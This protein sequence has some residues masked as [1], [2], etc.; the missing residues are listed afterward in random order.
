MLSIT[1][2][3]PDVIVKSEQSAPGRVATLVFLSFILITF[4]EIPS[5]SD[6]QLVN[7]D[8]DSAEISSIEWRSWPIELISFIIDTFVN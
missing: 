5:T 6:L 7:N 4:G 8:L 1:S 3:R 2:F